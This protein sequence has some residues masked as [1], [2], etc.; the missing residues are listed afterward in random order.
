M[1]KYS[2]PTFPNNSYLDNLPPWSGA[3]LSSYEYALDS[4][5]HIQ[6]SSMEKER[7]SNQTMEKPAGYLNL[8]QLGT[9][10]IF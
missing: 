5:T 9:S 2:L 8:N 3:E 1:D 4:V 7:N 10:H 6:K